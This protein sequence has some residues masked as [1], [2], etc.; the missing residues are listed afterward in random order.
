VKRKIKKD[1]KILDPFSLLKKRLKI[2]SEADLEDSI[3]VIAGLRDKQYD[4]KALEFQE[5]TGDG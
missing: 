1:K 4:D 5:S 3:K 2:L